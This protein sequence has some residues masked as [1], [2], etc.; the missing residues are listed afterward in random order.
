[1]REKKRLT[2]LVEKVE[3]K[4]RKI[5][6]AMKLMVQNQFVE[7][8]KLKKSKKRKESKEIKV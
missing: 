1:M 8:S 3:E 5:L 7:E 4:G 6:Y 2:V